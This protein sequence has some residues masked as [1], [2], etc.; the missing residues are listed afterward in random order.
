VPFEKEKENIN[1]I[2]LETSEE[3]S[4]PLEESPLV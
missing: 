3:E 1:I 2:Q 4:F